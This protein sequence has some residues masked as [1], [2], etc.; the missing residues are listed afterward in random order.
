MARK[1]APAAQAI[2]PIP[3]KA[4]G[5]ISRTEQQIVEMH[6]DEKTQLCVQFNNGDPFDFFIASARFDAAESLHDNAV[7]QMGSQLILIKAFTPGR[8]HKF[9]EER[10]HD[11]RDAQRHMQATRIYLQ[12]P[13]TK[14]LAQRL[15][16][17]K[18]YDL[19]RR[20]HEEVEAIANDPAAVDAIDLMS[21]AELQ[22]AMRSANQQQAEDTGHYQKQMSKEREKNRAWMGDLAEKTG[23]AL[24]DVSKYVTAADNAL[25][26]AESVLSQL[27][28]A[29]KSERKKPDQRTLDV[30]LA[31]YE[32]VS[33]QL[34]ATFNIIPVNG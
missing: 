26:S 24:E 5:A 33:E 18:L 34:E 27:R 13:A 7:L 30:L 29:F 14:A 22:A 9:L 12:S 10:G 3:P 20:G 1:A 11:A 2:A 4:A 15:P 19:M 23:V 21:R 8:F 17:G 32:R 25:H 31:F 6:E 16:K 28:D